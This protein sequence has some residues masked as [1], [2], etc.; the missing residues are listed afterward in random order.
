MENNLL[1]SPK[2]EIKEHQL[3]ITN[4]FVWIKLLVQNGIVLKHFSKY[5]K[6]TFFTVLS[7]PFQL[8]QYIYLS[9]KR[10]TKKE[11]PHDPIFII[12]HWRSGTTH[13]HYL[14]NLDDQFICLENF[15]AFFFRIAFVSRR[16]LRPV[17][18]QFMPDK[19]PQDNITINAFSPCEEEHPLTNLTALSGMQ[20]FF[21]GKNL[22]YFNK[23]NLHQG[24]TKRESIKW[25][26]TYH[27]MLLQIQWFNKS[28]KQLLL[29]N[30]HNTARVKLLLEKYPKAKFIYLHR[31]PLEVYSS[32][33][34]LYKK[35]ISTQHLQ[36]INNSDVKQNIIYFYQSTIEG[37]LKNR[38]LI[39][40]NQLIEISYKELDE[41]PVNTI[42]KIYKSLK[43]NG[44]KRVE[45]KLTSY[46][47]SLKDYKKN[48]FPALSIEDELSVRKKWKIG[49]EAWKY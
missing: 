25:I 48:N 6:I 19:R 44:F 30:P 32:M 41:A 15:Q 13:L 2:Q 21:F 3:Y 1:K 27:N 20:S 29:K 11:L 49:F 4:L 22:K 5:L 45:T 38:S 17:L 26:N 43:I 39:P 12:G 23:G 7:T 8:I 46:C 28:N 47:N 14:M 35:T 40:P 18:Q 24:L 9:P 34:H 31:N 36:E 42:N 37:Y 10:L 16:I 33:H